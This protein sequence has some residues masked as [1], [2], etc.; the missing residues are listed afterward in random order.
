MKQLLLF[1]SLYYILF[2]YSLDLK[3]R[4]SRVIVP[5]LHWKNEAINHIELMDNLLY[6]PGDSMKERIHS[7]NKNPIYNFLHTYYRGYSAQNL[8]KYSRGLGVL[9]ECSAMEDRDYSCL[10]EKYLMITPEGNLILNCI[11][12]M[13]VIIWNFF[14]VILLLFKLI[15]V[16]SNLRCYMA[17]WLFLYQIKYSRTEYHISVYLLYDRFS[18]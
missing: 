12:L 11:I 18:Q 6:P 2:I 17:L 5:L 3:N 8:K 9:M 7:I 1:F 4:S 15:A 10:N 14:S 16:I 13:G